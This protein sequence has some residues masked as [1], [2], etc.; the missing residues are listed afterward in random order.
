MGR[1]VANLVDEQILRWRI[2]RARQETETPSVRKARL[3]PDAITFSNAL[4]SGATIISRMVAGRLDLPLY[5]REVVTHIA[6]SQRIQVETV[7][8][9]DERAMGR[10]DDYLTSLWHERGFDQNDYIRALSKTVIAM[11]AHGRC[12]FH[13]HGAGHIL[14]RKHVLK[15]R[16]MAP[17]EVRVATVAQR[18]GLEMNVARKKVEQADTERERFIRKYFHMRIDD[19]L[20]YDLVF[21]TE[22]LSPEL[23][24]DA[25]AGA[26]RSRFGV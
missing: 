17:L 12:V 8:T 23:C 21:N 24:A 19:P 1:S 6:Q 10:L 25:I 9:L 4:G 18:D 2:E 13:G 11:W 7:E 5:G 16:L 22:H 20:N 15:V 3:S 14:P 26:Y